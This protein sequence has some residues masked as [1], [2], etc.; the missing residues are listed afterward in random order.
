MWATL[1]LVSTL[2]SAAEL[3]VNGVRATG[4]RDQTF[5]DADV[6]IDEHGDIH[7]T[8]PQYVVRSLDP[9]PAPDAPLQPAASAV[10]AG[11]YWMVTEDNR[12]TGHTI[13]V[14][15]NGDL[16][17]RVRSGDD[18]LILDLAP[19]L[20]PGSNNVTFSAL[21]GPQPAGGILHV[22]MGTGYN[23]AGVIRLHDPQID[24][25][26]RSSDKPTGGMSDFVL[27]IE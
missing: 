27:G 15:V 20:K 26:R 4:L 24:Y 14:F 7:V 5:T 23:D 25:A 1:L 3:Y 21:P 8:A 9:A 10:S 11:R 18:Q 19:W 2:A 17:R 13:E 16:V 22:Y 6:H 12:S